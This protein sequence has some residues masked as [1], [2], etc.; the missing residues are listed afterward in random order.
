MTLSS[1]DWLAI[2]LIGAGALVSFVGRRKVRIFGMVVFGIALVGFMF[3]QITQRQF[4]DNAIFQAPKPRQLGQA[5]KVKLL[6]RIPKSRKIR[7]M[8]QSGESDAGPL[9]E[10]IAD[11]LKSNGYSV[12]G[13]DAAMIFPTHRGVAVDLSEDHP[14]KPINISVGL[15]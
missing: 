9:A 12:V 10:Q 13:P 5:E 14:E 2:A 6:A 11:F 7:L 15:R 4:G 8:F 1:F 3:S